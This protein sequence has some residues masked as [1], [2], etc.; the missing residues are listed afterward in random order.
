VQLV[1]NAAQELQALVILT[2][3]SQERT[4]VAF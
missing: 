2:T 4:W 1:S 3:I